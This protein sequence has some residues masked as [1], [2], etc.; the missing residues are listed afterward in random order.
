MHPMSWR[1]VASSCI[2]WT[3]WPWWLATTAWRSWDSSLL[4]A[5]F[6]ELRSNYA[7]NLRCK[8]RYHHRV[9][10]TVYGPWQGQRV[11]ASPCCMRSRSKFSGSWLNSEC[12]TC[13]V[14]HGPWQRCGN[15]SQRWCRLYLRRY[16]LRS[17]TCRIFPTSSGPWHGSN[18]ETLPS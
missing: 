10:P 6:K 17:S 14:L 12:R 3:M 8:Q 7:A 9:S 13:Q 2:N 5:D 15:L 1:F 4:T 16:V 18:T 11:K